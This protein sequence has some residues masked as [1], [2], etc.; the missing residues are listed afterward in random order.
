MS[1]PAKLCAVLNLPD[2]DDRH[3]LGAA[4]KARAALIVSS[5]KKDFPQVALDEFEIECVL[6]DDFFA[7]TIDLSPSVAI[8]AL[9]RMRHRIQFGREQLLRRTEQIG[10]LLTADKMNEYKEFL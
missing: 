9:A 7:S 2:P 8:K 1:V 4:I 10:L 5:N 3:V 6:P